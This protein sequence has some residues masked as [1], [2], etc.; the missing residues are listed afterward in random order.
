M[1]LQLVRGARRDSVRAARTVRAHRADRSCAGVPG[2]S[3]I[4]VVTMSCAPAATSCLVQ[5]VAKAASLI[6]RVDLM[7]GG[8]LFFDPMPAA[9]A[10]VN[11]CAGG[12]AP[13]SHWMAVT[14]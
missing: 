11:F 5:R 9:A 1:G 4:G 10:R 13:R 12:I 2:E 6:H 7:P 14:R 3:R 8:H